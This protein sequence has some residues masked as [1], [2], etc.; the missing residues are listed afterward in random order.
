MGLALESFLSEQLGPRRKLYLAN[1]SSWVCKFFNKGTCMRGTEC[2][3]RHSRGDKPYVCKFWLRGLCKKGADVCESLHVYDPARMPLCQ[4]IIDYGAC[5]N[6]DCIFTHSREDEAGKEQKECIWYSR[7][8]CKHGPLCK[9]K[10]I[11]REMCPDYLA[12]FCP[13]GPSCLLGHPKWLLP[14]E[15]DAGQAQYDAAGNLIPGSDAPRMRTLRSLIGMALPSNLIPGARRGPSSMDEVQ[16]NLCHQMGH[17]AGSC[18]NRGTLSDETGRRA[19]RDLSSVQCFR[20][21][22]VGHYANFCKNERREPP[23]GGWTL[24]DGTKHVNKLKRT[25]EVSFL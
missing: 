24:P 18:P 25:R 4:F 13:L 14:A 21:G 16:C 1:G 11:R 6:P 17:F 15:L 2:P 9:S 12:G 5:H 20:C 22:E 8:F 19:P 10:H 7:G 23:P 3:Y